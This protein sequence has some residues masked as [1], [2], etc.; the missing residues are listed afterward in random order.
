[1]GLVGVGNALVDMLPYTIG[2]I[3]S[4]L[5]VV[6]VVVLLVSQGGLAKSAV[7]EVAWLVTSFLVV[8]G[9]AEAVAAA[10]PHPAGEQPAWESWLA[11]G[12]GLV[13]LALAALVARAIR[14][15]RRNPTGQ[16][17]PPRWLAVIDRLPPGRVVGLAV[18][19]IVANPVNAS[20]LV[21]GAVEL[22]RER[23]PTSQNLLLAALFV[24]IGSLSVLAPYLV[25]TLAGKRSGLLP[26]A[27]EWLLRNNNILSFGMALAF[28]MIF[29][30]RGLR[31]L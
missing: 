10:D 25:A 13:L 24:L 23:L 30:V 29:L 3:V 19:L 22:G 6:A 17:A 16:V 12:L 1:M 31:G 7:F 20:M 21:A 11:I 4:P 2:L 14:R 27:R 8:W 18:A 15:Q 26:A 9:L 28:G 5:P